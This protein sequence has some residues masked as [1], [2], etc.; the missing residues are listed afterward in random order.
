MV[1]GYDESTEA[2]STTAFYDLGATINENH[3]LGDFLGLPRCL[4][5]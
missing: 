1:T 2:E 4:G 3:F 5:A